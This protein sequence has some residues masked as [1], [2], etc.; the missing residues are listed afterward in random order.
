MYRILG[1]TIQMSH[2]GGRIFKHCSLH[3]N[4][5]LSNEINMKIE[6]AYHDQYVEL[7]IVPHQLGRQKLLLTA[8]WLELETFSSGLTSELLRTVPRFCSLLPSPRH[9]R[10]S[11]P[12]YQM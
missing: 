4:I 5:L 11:L 12:L 3:S 1:V 6:I 10:H 7:A 2:F 9:R 8:L